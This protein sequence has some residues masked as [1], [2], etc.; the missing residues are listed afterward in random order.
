MKRISIFLFFCLVTV[1]FAASKDQFELEKGLLD[2]LYKET[3]QETASSS[4][5]S[6]RG[7]VVTP[8]LS[9][10]NASDLTLSNN[11]WLVSYSSQ[12]SGVPAF[13]LQASMPFSNWRGF[14]F[15]IKGSVSYSFKE[16]LLK[17]TSKLT[18]AETRALLTLHTLPLSVGGRTEYRIP[19]LPF[20]YP[21]LDLELGTQWFYQTGKLDGIAQ[22]FWVPFYQTTF[23]LTL[24]ESS[25]VRN[26]WFGGI[27]VASSLRNS[28]ASQQSV[29]IWSVDI[30]INL[31]L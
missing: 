20:L 24:F 27:D 9:F 5:L 25:E 13:G 7:L 15:L 12:L 17:A 4:G 2:T 18:S 22:S 6:S 14:S 1:S 3:I 19:G 11:Y 21:H 10:F 23:G 29:Q 30:G 26:N 31:Y 16:T 8:K 28:F